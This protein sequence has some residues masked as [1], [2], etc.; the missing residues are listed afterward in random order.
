[1]SQ[2][3]YY[4]GY[5]IVVAIS[6]QQLN[7]QLANLAKSGQLPKTWQDP[8]AQGH[9]WTVDAEFGDPYIDFPVDL[10]NVARLNFP[11]T[12][13]TFTSYNTGGLGHSVASE[14]VNLA[15]NVLGIISPMGTK[16]ESFSDSTLSIKNIY[17]DLNSAQTKTIVRTKD[18]VETLVVDASTT[19]SLA[20]RFQTEIRAKTNGS[21]I[22]NSSI[23]RDTS[24]NYVTGCLEPVSSDFSV[25]RV[26]DR[27]HPAFDPRRSDRTTMNWLLS[28]ESAQ[29]PSGDH[30]LLGRFDSS[31][32]PNDENGVMI[33][34]FAALVE[35]VIL[36]AI[37]K[38]APDLHEADMASDR[39]SRV[40]LRSV[41]G[42]FQNVEIYPDGGQIRADFTVVKSV[43]VEVTLGDRTLTNLRNSASSTWSTLFTVSRQNDKVVMDVKHSKVVA[44]ST[45]SD[46]LS[47]FS[48]LDFNKYDPNSLRD[49]LDRDADPAGINRRLEQLMTDYM[50]RVRI[51]GDKQYDLHSARILNGNLVLGLSVQN[52]ELLDPADAYG[53]RSVSSSYSGQSYTFHNLTG[54]N[55]KLRWIDLEGRIRQSWGNGSTP[56]L[57]APGSTCTGLYYIN[58][59]F[60]VYDQNDQPCAF[61]RFTGKSEFNQNTDIYIR[62]YVRL[63]DDRNLLSRYSGSSTYVKFVNLT[64][65]N[66]VVYWMSASNPRFAS[67]HEV[68][69]LAPNETGGFC[70]TSVGQVFSVYDEDSRV[71]LG[72]YRITFPT[73]TFS[74]QRQTIELI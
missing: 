35:C 64:G 25:F 57:L 14:S 26:F 33:V 38:A 46:L 32:L 44:S 28:T 53:I 67:R 52:Y 47:F 71:F 51:L 37:Q 15:E 12:R 2:L 66:V 60:G 4:Q 40:W 70:Q 39:S 73:G 49:S 22:F 19:A 41:F 65:K 43:N 62:S 54:A 24:G 55:I 7:L 61:Y 58:H 30:Q 8:A 5:P 10:D 34:S 59:V 36:P 11:I 18:D 13:G 72:A 48:T 63:T 29:P 23:T 6:C 31:P 45:Y 69:K 1:M 56:E 16:H 27:S 74:N 50:S 42:P 21:L 20:E 17:L 3:P 68:G 9:S